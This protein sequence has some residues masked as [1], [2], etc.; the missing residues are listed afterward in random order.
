MN[1]D[2]T[3]ILLAIGRTG[4]L[5]RSAKLLGISVSTVH[6]RAVELEK[7]LN[8]VL[9]SRDSDGYTLTHV[10]K[11]FFALAEKAEEH[12]IAMERYND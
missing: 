1:W 11:H 10:G 4:G 8:A 7:S 12:L 5:S 6:R 9:F 3:K 2:D